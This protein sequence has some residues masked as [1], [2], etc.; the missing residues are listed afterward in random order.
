MASKLG[1]VES[2]GT[3][4]FAFGEMEPRSRA[5][6]DEAGEGGGNVNVIGKMSGSEVFISAAKVAMGDVTSGES[7]GVVER[8]PVSVALVG[9]AC[10]IPGS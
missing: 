4:P 1:T 10:R 5:A 7:S 8:W 3:N 2:G 9:S 6:R